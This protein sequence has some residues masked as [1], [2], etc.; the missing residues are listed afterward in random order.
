MKIR[1]ELT[2]NFKKEAKPLLKKYISL[3]SDLLSLE[4]EL[5]VN[6]NLGTSL[7]NNLYKIRL[8]IKSK[9]KGKSGGA[10]VISHVDT[11]LIGSVTIAEF[12]MVVSLISIYDKSETANITDKELKKLLDDLIKQ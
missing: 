9:N 7:G 8:Q 5:L 11:E 10:R 12:E 2:V 3:K 4:K 1:I 6:P